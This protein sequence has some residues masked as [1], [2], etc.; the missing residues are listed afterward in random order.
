MGGKRPLEALLEKG[1]L[2]NYFTVTIKNALYLGEDYE[3]V[4]TAPKD[5]AVQLAER[6]QR[7]TKTPVTIIGEI[8]DRKK[9]I[10]LVDVKGREHP[11]KSGGYEHFKQR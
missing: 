1:K 11:L 2:R 6:N 8:V 9:G 7:K 3:L 4:F 10:K 5:R